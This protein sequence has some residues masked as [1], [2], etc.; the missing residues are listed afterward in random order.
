MTKEAVQR[1]NG[2]VL[3]NSGQL[4]KR[5]HGPDACLGDF[6]PVH[7]PSDHK[8]RGEQLFFNGR[9]MVRRVGA[10]LFID[11]DDF[12]YRQTG[13]AILRN[14]ATCTVCGD[15][16]Q[17]VGQHDFRECSCGAI[18]VDGG[19]E[20]MRNGADDYSHFIDTSVIVDDSNGK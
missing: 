9:H 4:V 1:L 2:D 5:F 10:E 3:F 13:R 16:I 14:S 19:F 11:P 18:F 6:C 20:Y 15:M 12:V 17:S 7:N 8:L